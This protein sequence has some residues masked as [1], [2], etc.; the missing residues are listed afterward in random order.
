MTNN[1]VGS[2]CASDYKGIRNQDIDDG[3]WVV[4]AAGDQKND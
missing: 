4:Q 2:I 1:I 3:K